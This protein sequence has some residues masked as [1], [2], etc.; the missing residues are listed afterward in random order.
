[1]VHKFESIIVHSLG[2]P[3]F[4]FFLFFF[5]DSPYSMVVYLGPSMKHDT[6]YLAEPPRDV[7]HRRRVK[8]MQMIMGQTF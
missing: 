2:F 5:C 7:L 1:M 8:F 3:L 6:G 4:V